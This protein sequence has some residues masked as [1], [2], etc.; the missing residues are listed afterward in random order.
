MSVMLGARW[1][2]PVQNDRLA[3][4]R[5]EGLIDY[6]EVNYPIPYGSEPHTLD[7]PVLAHTS[8]NPTCSVH[9]VNPVVAKYVKEGAER[10]ES[11]WIGEHLTWLG[12]AET[13]SL[14]Y[15]INPLF[16]AD[17]RDVAVENIRRLKAYYDRDIA[18]ELSPIYVDATDYD[19]E[20]HFLGDVAAEADT[21]IILDVTHWQIANRNLER[22]PEYGFDGLDRERIVELHVAGMRLGNDGFWH[23]AHQIEP[24]DQI[25]ERV[26]ALA[27]DLPK[28]RAVTLEHQ[29]TAPEDAFFN[30]LRRLN[31]VMQD[32]R[33]AA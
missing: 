4:A 6:I 16:T 15:Q 21:G 26:A 12:A 20:M 7:I 31:A 25:I 19:S 8:S 22:P 24:S 27:H 10:A 28:L 23:D 29:G 11:P 3:R 17:F 14:G 9:G 32:L 33:P 30:A 13:G 2:D 1:D 5:D 18:L